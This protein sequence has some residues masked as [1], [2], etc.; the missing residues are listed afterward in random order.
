MAMRRLAETAAAAVDSD[1][2]VLILGE[3]GCGKGV[4]DPRKWRA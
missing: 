2:P 4:L 1:V 3:T